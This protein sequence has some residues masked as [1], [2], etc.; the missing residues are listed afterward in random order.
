MA[1]KKS[2]SSAKSAKTK[3]TKPKT[4]EK[5]VKKSEIEAPKT[6]TVVTTSKKSCLAGLF[7][8]KYEEKESVFTVFK[9]PKFSEIRE[10][11]P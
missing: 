4:A 3:T 10:P 11:L 6:N 2:K 8:K 7:A 1:T 5:S 9:T